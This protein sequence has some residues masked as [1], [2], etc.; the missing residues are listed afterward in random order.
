[1]EAIRL[2]ENEFGDVLDVLSQRGVELVYSVESEG[3]FVYGS[4]DVVEQIEDILWARQVMPFVYS[5]AANMR[6]VMPEI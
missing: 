1:M 3:V 2:R 6:Y 5:K 4:D